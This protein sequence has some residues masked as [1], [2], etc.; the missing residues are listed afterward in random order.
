MKSKVLKL[1]K[2]LF[3]GLFSIFILNSKVFS[4]E[5][6]F[7]AN[8]FKTICSDTKL[9][10]TSTNDSIKRLKDQIYKEA[11][12]N[13]KPK[14]DKLEKQYTDMW[15][16]KDRDQ[17]RYI[18]LNQEIM[19]S[20]NSKISGLETLITNMKSI[21]IIKNYMKLAIDESNFKESTR[22]AFRKT[23][24][25][26]MIGSF[27]DYNIKNGNKY[28]LTKL[29]NSPCGVD[30]MEVNAFSTTILNQKYV[31][32]CPGLLIN[33]G[34]NGNEQERL[35]NILFAI[36]HEIGH[37]I[38]RSDAGAEVF[39][40]YIS[41]IVDHYSGGLNRSLSDVSFCSKIA[42]NDKECRI[43]VTVSHSSELIADQWAI[44]ALAIYARTNRYSVAQT[45]SLL[46][47]N[48]IKLCGRTDQ[49][50]HPSDKFRMESL[51]RINPEISDYLSCDNS[52]VKK[53]ACTFDGEVII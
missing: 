10:M 40:P 17:L 22:K 7:C 11:V 46:T 25:S 51:L 33:Y 52:K 6:K 45:D 53:P 9:Q 35:S 4:S 12:K 18:I 20:A 2:V 41:C 5:S 8:P 37:H 14:I 48:Y 26:V 30:G 13:A 34:K 44:Q 24:D 42:R 16:R 15:Y 50:I 3:I 31:L 19:K 21:S 43:Q 49:G 27:K 32:I 36:T 38:E 39:I 23:I 1:I 28:D 47:N 29:K